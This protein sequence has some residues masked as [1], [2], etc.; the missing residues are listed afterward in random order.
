MFITRPLDRQEPKLGTNTGEARLVISAFETG[1][2][3][4]PE[5]G[6]GISARRAWRTEPDLVEDDPT[7]PTRKLVRQIMGAI[8]EYEKSLIV[9][10][11]RGA[12]MRM[13]AKAGRC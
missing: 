6:S 7:N 10:K 4:R 2:A 1:Q 11:L 5:I 12:R 13:R 9:L 3:I 8:A